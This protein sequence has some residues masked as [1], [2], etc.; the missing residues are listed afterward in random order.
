MK[1]RQRIYTGICKVPQ[2][3][4]RNVI[5]IPGEE[6]EESTEHGMENID[7]GSS[8]SEPETTTDN[9]DLWST[10]ET[11]DEATAVA[12]RV[13]GNQ[14]SET[15]NPPGNT[16]WTKVTRWGWKLVLKTCNCHYILLM[17]I[18]NM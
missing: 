11:K 4:Q 7:F 14:D 10:D 17:R 15:E 8:T 13:I 3:I 18:K 12:A 2:H 9:M 5:N 6:F 1:E 16:M